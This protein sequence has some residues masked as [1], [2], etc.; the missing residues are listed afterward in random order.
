MDDEASDHEGEERVVV[1]V[2]QDLGE[3]EAELARSDFR[4]NLAEKL[5]VVMNEVL[6]ALPVH[7]VARRSG[8]W[9]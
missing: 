6:D 1:E 7:V 5:K 8:A 3:T 4:K 2:A 9:A